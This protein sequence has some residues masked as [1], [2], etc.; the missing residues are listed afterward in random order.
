MGAVT[1]RILHL[2]R[3]STEDGP[4]IRTTV[5]FKGCPLRCAWCHNPESLSP[6]LEIQWYAG[7]CLGCRTCVGTCPLGCLTLSGA[8]LAIDRDRCDGCGLCAEACPANA[9]EALGKDVTVEAMLRELVKDRAYY[10]ASGGGVT[11]SGGEPTLQPDFAEA[12]LC[13]LKDQ[14]IATALDTCGMCSSQVLDRLLPFTDLILYDLKLY[15]PEPHQRLTGGPNGPILQNL[16]HL[17][18]RTRNLTHPP[19]LWIRTPLIPGATATDQNLRDLGRFLSSQ[20]DGR[21]SR[22]ELCAFNNLCRDKYQR[23]GLA[24]AYAQQTLM[25][26]VELAHFEEVARASGLAPERVAATGATL[27][28]ETVRSQ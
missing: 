26:A 24:W 14:G 15:S 27:A 17:R 6:R 16:L 21:V 20:L 5:F 8:G 4:G 2:Q 28:V 10:Q 9:V 3:L 11:L 13:G 12:L 22:W 7:R 1:G 23:L 19:E 18:D 25:T